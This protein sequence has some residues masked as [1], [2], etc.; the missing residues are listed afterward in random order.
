MTHALPGLG[1][2]AGDEQRSTT[3]R[4]TYEKELQ[5]EGLGG[6]RAFVLLGSSASVQ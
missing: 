1:D 4:R 6:T 5:R 2:S 3:R